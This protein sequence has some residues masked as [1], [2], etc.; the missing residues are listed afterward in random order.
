[1]PANATVAK[2]I[3]AARKRLEFAAGADHH[4]IGVEPGPGRALA[5]I[6][7]AHALQK[8]LNQLFAVELG[9]EFGDQSGEVLLELLA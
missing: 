5:G 7:V 2:A 8:A 1:M 9:V 3:A 4:D 6:S